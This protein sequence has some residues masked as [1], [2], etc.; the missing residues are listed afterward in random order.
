MRT[1]K[2]IAISS[3]EYLLPGHCVYLIR[4]ERILIHEALKAT[5]AHFGIIFQTIVSRWSSPDKMCATDLTSP[6]CRH[7]CRD[8]LFVFIVVF[9]S[10]NGDARNVLLCTVWKNKCFHSNYTWLRELFYSFFLVISIVPWFRSLRYESLNRTKC[11]VKH[12]KWFFAFRLVLSS[13]RTAYSAFRL[14]C[15]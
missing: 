11:Y 4:V 1:W 7:N 12:T 6:N 14:R 2:I 3:S 13:C 10:T 5:E 8:S 9:I 15:V